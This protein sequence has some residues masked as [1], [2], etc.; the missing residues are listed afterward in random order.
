MQ[1]AAVSSG[2]AMHADHAWSMQLNIKYNA[3]TA[4]LRKFRMYYC[5][6]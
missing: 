2:A 3:I 4:Q 1:S 5:T 6:S